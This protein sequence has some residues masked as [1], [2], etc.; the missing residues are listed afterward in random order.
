MNMT[1][2]FSVI[3]L[4]DELAFWH[5]LMMHYTLILKKKAT[6]ITFTLP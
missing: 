6:S 1:E 3:P 4:I 2:D 5:V